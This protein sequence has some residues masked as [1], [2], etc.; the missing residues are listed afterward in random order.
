MDIKTIANTLVEACRTQGEAA[1]L[2]D[3]YHPDA[4]SV[5]AADFSGMGRETKGV[6]GIRGKHAWWAE[7]FEVHGG[8][9]SGPYLHGDD[10]FAVTFMID[11][12]HKASGER[13]KMNEV[14][15]YTVENG[16]IIREEF[17][18]SE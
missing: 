8:D 1:L 7:N 14:A 2:D 18:A 12:T 10:K 4:V 6:D 16:K 9:V 11:A 13:S 3:H 5:E 17:F 15:I